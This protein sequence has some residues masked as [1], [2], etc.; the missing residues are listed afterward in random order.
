M[1]A[2]QRGCSV[3]V[4][5]LVVLGSSRTGLGQGGWSVA[6]GPLTG[7]PVANA[8]FS[9]DATTTVRQTLSDGRLIERIATA[10]YFRDREGRVRV[11]QSINGSKEI[12]PSATNVPRITVWPDPA[13][14]GAYAYTLEPLTRTARKGPRD[15]AGEA[16]GGGDT[17]AAPLGGV[18]FLIFH[19]A[20]HDPNATGAVTEESLGSRLIAGVETVGRRLTAT[21][22]HGQAG[23]Q[24]T[25]ERWESRELK[26]LMFGHSSSSNPGVGIVDY[27]LSNVRRAEPDPDLFVVPNDYTIVSSPNEW[28]T[29][30]WA[31]NTQPAARNDKRRR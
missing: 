30:E 9:A 20:L 27:R 11:E 12:V 14:S 13:A 22:P 26:I 19:S 18:R 16:V 31:E 7:P 6:G 2:M 4:C 17:F 25:E 8:P 24:V 1:I 3:A 15:I 5:L 28:I 21:I 10:R 23:I 29:L